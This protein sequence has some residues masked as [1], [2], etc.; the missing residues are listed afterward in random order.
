MTTF[1]ATDDHLMT[2]EEVAAE[3][4]HISPE[5]AD[6]NYLYKPG[7]PYVLPSGAKRR[8]YQKSEVLQWLHENQKYNK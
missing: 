3:I 7:F 4:L 2:R 6:K 1:L 5:T 8:A